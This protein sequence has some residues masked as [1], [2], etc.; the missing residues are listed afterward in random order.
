M[1][2]CYHGF[3]HFWCDGLFYQA[4]FCY[5]SG[6]AMLE[7]VVYP[8]YGFYP[9]SVA[10]GQAVGQSVEVGFGIHLNV[11]GAVECQDRACYPVKQLA[12]IQ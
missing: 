10:G 2:P 7:Q 4:V 11:L 9:V 8:F 12:H 6:G 1:Y 5:S 3:Q